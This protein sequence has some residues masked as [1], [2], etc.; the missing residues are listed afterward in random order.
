VKIKKAEDLSVKSSGY[1][2]FNF[3][4]VEL[5]PFSVA[6]SAEGEYLE[7]RR[8]RNSVYPVFDDLI[9]IN[10]LPD[11]L[12][13]QTLMCYVYDENKISPRDLI[14]VAMLE[15]HGLFQS[16]QGKEKDFDE[17]L[18]WRKGVCELFIFND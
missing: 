11:E 10:I 9:T 4:Q 13:E 8:V 17:T 18:E 12:K 3:V 1:V 16:I 7:T 2:S 15:M 6:R 14:G 5:D